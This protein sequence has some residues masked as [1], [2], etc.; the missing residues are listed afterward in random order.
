MEIIG[1]IILGLSIIITLGWCINIR[2]KATYEQATEKA[3]E[4]QGF[5]MTASIILVFVIPLS[6]FHL[7]WMLP[8]SFILGLLSVTTPLK[9]LWI[10][11]SIY[12][13]FWYIGISNPGRKFFLD[14]DYKKAVAALK[15]EI[16]KKPSSAEAYFN[17]ALAYGKLGQHDNEISAYEEASKLTPNK[18]ETYFNLGNAYIDKGD[19][20]KAIEV[21][22]QAISLR[23]D[24]LKAHYIMCKTYAEIG[25]KENALKELEIVR[26]T[27]SRSADELASIIKTV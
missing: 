15:D 21:F 6:S 18:P 19:K 1:Y 4:L 20:H 24:Y 27:D 11:S 9:V 16:N 3:M 22:K 2:H 10:F 5:L 8:V 25:D 13:S 17:L 12:F 23:P 14:G 26:K 7:L